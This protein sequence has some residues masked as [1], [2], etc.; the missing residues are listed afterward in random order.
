MKNVHDFTVKTID[1]KTKKLSDYKGDVL[2]VV[3]VASECGYT[4]QYAGLERL[5]QNA[6]PP[7]QA[8]EEQAGPQ[9]GE[10]D[11]DRPGLHLRPDPRAAGELLGDTGQ[12]PRGGVRR[13]MAV[14]HRREGGR[15]AML[16]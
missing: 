13:Q 3:N 2:L 15:D 16:Q 12:L 5:A 14:E 8:A 9:K 1:G 7:R 11:V 6:H 10:A 4:P